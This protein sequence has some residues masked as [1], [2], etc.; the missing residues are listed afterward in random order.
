VAGFAAVPQL[1]TYVL[2]AQV[3]WQLDVIEFTAHVPSVPPPRTTV[4]QH[5]VPLPHWSVP[6]LPTQSR[7]VAGDVQLA[8]HVSVFVG[9]FRQQ[10]S[11]AAHW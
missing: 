5:I 8:A 10:S 11:P 2:S 3:V 9:E 6:V 1:D 7:A 4:A